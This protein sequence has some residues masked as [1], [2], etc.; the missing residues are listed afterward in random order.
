MVTS[1]VGDHAS[2]ESRQRRQRRLHEVDVPELGLAL[3]TVGR[4]RA[5]EA[6]ETTLEKENLS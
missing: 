1:S 3:A 2:A 6:T 4:P 5:V